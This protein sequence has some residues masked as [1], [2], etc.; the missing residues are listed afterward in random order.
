MPLRIPLHFLHLFF[1]GRIYCDAGEA[2]A[3]KKREVAFGQGASQDC[4]K[5][6]PE[7]PFAAIEEAA[8]FQY[9]SG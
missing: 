1:A 2:V 4:G 3:G 5:A 6:G 7:Q 8:E 9:D